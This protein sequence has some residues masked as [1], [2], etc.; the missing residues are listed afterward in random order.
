MHKPDREGG[1]Y[2]EEIVTRSLT[3]SPLLTRGLVHV[4]V[5]T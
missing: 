3:I 5:V 1:R 2:A 4:G